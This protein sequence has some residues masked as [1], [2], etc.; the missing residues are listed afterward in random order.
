MSVYVALV[1]CFLFMAPQ[2]TKVTIHSN[3]MQLFINFH[4]EITTL[5]KPLNLDDIKPI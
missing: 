5:A 3:L 2:M 1:H 4:D